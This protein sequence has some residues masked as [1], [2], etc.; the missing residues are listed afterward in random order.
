M[1]E[2]P[3]VIESVALLSGVC[4]CGFPHMVQGHAG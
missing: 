2:L 1:G 3:L 4:M